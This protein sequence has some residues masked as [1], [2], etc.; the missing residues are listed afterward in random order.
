VG[1]RIPWDYSQKISGVAALGKARAV[2][3]SAVVAALF[4]G[5]SD[6]RRFVV[7]LVVV[8]FVFFALVI[9]VVRVSRWPCVGHHGDE[10]PVRQR[11]G[12]GLISGDVRNHV[13]SPIPPKRPPLE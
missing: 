3:C 7:V 9:I 6:D 8:L 10:A 11:A 2:E 12:K 1:I 13:G 4:V 5:F